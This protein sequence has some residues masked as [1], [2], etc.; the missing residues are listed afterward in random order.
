MNA[1]FQTDRAW[2]GPIVLAA[3][4][5]VFICGGRLASHGRPAP[6]LVNESPSLPRGLYGRRPGAKPGR[7][8]VVAVLQPAAAQAYLA[9]QGMPADVLLIKRVAAVGGD[10]VCRHGGRVTWPGG[11]TTARTQDRRGAR[12]PAWSGCRRL[13]ADALFLLGD[14]ASSFDSRYFGPVSRSRATGVYREVLTW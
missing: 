6:W 7:G 9:A 2:G 3:V 13:E 1:R 12:L 10:R 14:T 8:D 4:L 5:G 11:R